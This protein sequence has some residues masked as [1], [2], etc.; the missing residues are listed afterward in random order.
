MKLSNEIKTLIIQEYESFKEYMYANSPQN[1]REQLGQYFTPA[2]ASIQMLEA[3]P[4]DSLNGNI[5]DPCSGSGNLLVAALIAGADSAKIFGNELDE[6]MVSACR[7]R[8]KNVCK[9]LNKPP[10]K[11][12]Q[13]HRGNALIPD[14]LNNFGPEYDKTILKELLKKRWGLSGG[15][16]ENP[17][18][19]KEPEAYD[20]FSQVYEELNNIKEEN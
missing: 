7:V 11:D 16:L 15:W 6:N 12:W 17:D 1:I 20:L 14:C 10:I 9:M 3:L 8:L 13:I 5:L 2:G 19:Y 18:R 4:D